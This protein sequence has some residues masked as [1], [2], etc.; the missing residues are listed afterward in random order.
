MERGLV[1]FSVHG[2]QVQASSW[3]VVRL[4]KTQ[5]IETNKITELKEISSV[6]SFVSLCIFLYLA[7]ASAS[8][9]LPASVKQFPRS[10]H[11]RFRPFKV[12][13]VFV[14]ALFTLYISGVGPWSRKRSIPQP[15][16]KL[17]LLK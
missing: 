1:L 14:V 7:P 5:T 12:S 15:T 16:V 13:H 8:A 4:K 11:F 10:S 2:Q 9:P 3:L 6:S 17:Y